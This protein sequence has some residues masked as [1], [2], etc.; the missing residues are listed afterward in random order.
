MRLQLE[1]AAIFLSDTHLG[2]RD[3]QAEALLDFLDNVTAK[4]YYLNGDILDLWRIAQN[5]WV[6]YPSHTAVCNKFLQ[7]AADPDNEVSYE[8]GNHDET[9]RFLAKFGFLVGNI[10]VTNETT[11]VGINGKRYLVTHGD[12]YDGIGSLAPWLAHVGDKAYDMI[13]RVN[14]WFN[15]ARRQFG[16]GYWSLSKWMKSQVKSA[17]GFIFQFEKNLAAH[18]ERL[19]YDGVIC[20][21]IHHAEIKRIGRIDYMNSGDWVESCSALVEHLDGRWEIIYW[22][23]GNG[24]K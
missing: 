12:L 11:H 14:S 22:K 20:G 19:E 18:A 23:V 9:F 13:L 24:N 10:I 17:V 6:W 4:K 7:I 16:F 3:C 8:P 5:K 1:V 21:H 15:A 2:T